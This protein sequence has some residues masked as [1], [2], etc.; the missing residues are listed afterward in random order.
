MAITLAGRRQDDNGLRPLKPSRD[1]R[2][3]ADLIE[4]AFAN[5]LDR[6]GR[7][8]LREMRWLGRWGLLLL[9][10][11]FLSPDVNTHFSGFVWTDR[12]R[13]VGNA[14]VSRNAPGSRHWFI[15]NVAVARPYRGRGIARQLMEA[16]IEYV[17]E[18]RGRAISLQV[19]RDNAPA[20]HLYESLGFRRITAV[21]FFFMPRPLPVEPLPL[22]AGVVLRPHRLDVRDSRATY[23]LARLSTPPHVQAEKP[24]LQS[25]FRLGSEIPFNN[26][27]RALAGLGRRKYW[28]VETQGGGREVVGSLA[29]EPGLWHTE[30]RLA[31]MVHPAWRGRLEKPLISRALAYL[32]TCRPSRPIAFRHTEEH[33]EGIEALQHFGF[34]I[35]KTHL[36][37]KLE[38]GKP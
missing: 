30:H 33:A 38:L 29:V 1:L 4:S 27:W 37:M 35:E 10:L 7:A 31:F 9:W 16:A 13:I 15:S 3:V 14:T 24:L 26:F 12:G 20:V 28:L 32:Q 23:E 5:E 2:G 21:S 11:D 25:R 36:W 18:M 22:P 19:R 17:R 6:P 8:A 34:K